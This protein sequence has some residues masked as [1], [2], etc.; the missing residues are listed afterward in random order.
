MA[1][2]VSSRELVG[3]REELGLLLGLAPGDAALVVG[4]AG[5]GKSR[6]VRELARASAVPVHAGE[7]MPSAGADP[8]SAPVAGALRDVVRAD[9]AG[10]PE[11]ARLWPELGEPAPPA[12]G[13]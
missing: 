11:L 12:P 6:L 2:R 5:V 9:D 1:H 8:P 3:R 4:E 13:G 10:R 7:C